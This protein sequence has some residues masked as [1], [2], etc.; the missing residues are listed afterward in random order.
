MPPFFCRRKPLTRTPCWLDAEQRF[1][2]LHRV[3]RF[4]QVSL[5][6][7]PRNPK[8]RQRSE[9]MQKYVWHVALP[10]LEPK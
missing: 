7:I 6:R 4:L 3:H 9:G 8:I 10:F 5:A 1:W 2:R